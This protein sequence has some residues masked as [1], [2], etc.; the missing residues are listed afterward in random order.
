MLSTK[1]STNKCVHLVLHQIPAC[2]LTSHQG[3]THRWGWVFQ[4][5]PGRELTT[6]EAVVTAPPSPSLSVNRSRLI[7]Q[8]KR[9]R[10][11]RR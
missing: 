8:L 1:K 10:V 7:L 6:H 2:R 9:P 3:G 5:D 11:R 4:Q